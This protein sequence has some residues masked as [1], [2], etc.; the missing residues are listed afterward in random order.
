MKK[1]LDI[2]L[3]FEVHNEIQTVLA[4]AIIFTLQEAI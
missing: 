3:L 4:I 1:I 2:W